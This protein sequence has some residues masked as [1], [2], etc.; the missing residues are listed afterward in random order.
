MSADESQPQYRDHRVLDPSGEVIGTVEDVIFDEGTGSPRWAVVKPGVLHRSH[1]VP[2]AGAQRNDD[3]DVLVPYP[4]NVVTSAPAASSEHVLS[5][6]DEVALEEHYA[7]SA[8][9]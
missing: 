3:G 5:P 4:A 1:Y 7:G 2:L 9:D 8:G 6:A